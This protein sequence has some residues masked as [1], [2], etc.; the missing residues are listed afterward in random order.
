[1]NEDTYDNQVCRVEI[2][3]CIKVN[4]AAA[5]IYCTK[6][7]NVTAVHCTNSIRREPFINK[8]HNN[9]NH[10]DYYNYIVNQTLNN[11]DK[12]QYNN[13]NGTINLLIFYD[14]ITMLEYAFL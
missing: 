5:A 8:H 4:N 1:M 7:N 14:N 10:A 13:N 3:D 6:T 12:D 9:N 11:S 2:H